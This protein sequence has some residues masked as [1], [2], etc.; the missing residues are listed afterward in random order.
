MRKR[1]RLDA[2]SVD[3]QVKRRRRQHRKPSRYVLDEPVVRDQSDDFCFRCGK[4]GELLMCGSCPKVFHLACLDPPLSKVPEGDWICPVCL[5]QTAP[6][7]DEV[8]TDTPRVQFDTKGIEMLWRQ[9]QRQSTQDQQTLRFTVKTLREQNVALVKAKNMLVSRAATMK[10]EIAALQLQHAASASQQG[11]LQQVLDQL[12]DQSKA[13]PHDGTAGPSHETELLSPSAATA[14]PRPVLPSTTQSHRAWHRPP[15]P[16]PPPATETTL[17][18][19]PKLDSKVSAHAAPATKQMMIDIEL[20]APAP[21]PQPPAVLADGLGGP[22]P[23]GHAVAA[24]AA[25]AEVSA[26]GITAV[27]PLKETALGGHPAAAVAPSAH[28]HQVLN[29]LSRM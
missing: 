24:G 8:A 11:S 17:P 1:Q 16:P 13:G 27:Q 15:P 9:Y 7:L 14:P 4:F 10:A 22:P 12:A 2:T 19:N 3:S 29:I 18:F 6:K 28:T 21:P 20:N 25:A 23:T 5:P 26:S